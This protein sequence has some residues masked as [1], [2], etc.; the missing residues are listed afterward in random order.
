VIFFHDGDSWFRHAGEK[1]YAST[2]RAVGQLAFRSDN[3]PLRFLRTGMPIENEKESLDALVEIYLNCTAANSACQSNR[4]QR[5]C[6][7]GK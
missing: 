2:M 5:G 3:L 6:W 7:P 4:R 1:I